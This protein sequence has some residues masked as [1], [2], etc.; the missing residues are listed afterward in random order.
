LTTGDSSLS[1][2]IQSI[3]AAEIGYMDKALEYAY[4]A[5]LMDL[6]DEGG[7]VK[8]G[9][10]I[11]SMGASWMVLVCGFGGMRDFNGVLSFNPRLPKPIKR[12]R[13]PLT[14]R[15]QV[16]E[17]AMEQEAATYLLREGSELTIT[18]QDKEIRLS[19]GEP[20][21]VKIQPEQQV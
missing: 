2:G 10:H 1:V 12:L 13:F 17:V 5:V 3:L 15:G 4:Y 14:F 19:V 8:D 11:A 7:N 16:L 9:C 20:V 21:T 6:E 18:H